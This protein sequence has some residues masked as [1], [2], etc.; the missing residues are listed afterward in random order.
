M[1][2][3]DIVKLLA[4][5][6]QDDVF[7]PECKNGPTH[8]STHTRLDAWA[9]KK[10][11]QNPLAIG[12]EIKV[13]RGDFLRDEKWR[14]YLGLCNQFYFVAP[15]GVIKPEEVPKPAGLIMVSATGSRLFT[16]LKAQYRE[17]QIPDSL[18]RYVLFSRV[19]VVDEYNSVVFTRS[20]KLAYWK[21][22]MEDKKIDQ[23]F[24]WQVSRSIGH[25]VEE[26]INKANREAERAMSLV[27][28]YEEFKKV[29]ISNGIDPDTSR[30]GFD[31]KVKE[32]LSGIPKTM[33]DDL[34]R[35]RNNI[36]T[37]E[38]NLQTVRGIV[39]SPDSHRKG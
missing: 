24:G 2:A 11:W 13:S 18:F 31:S 15:H 37:M 16:K 26:E 38:K 14:S 29:L 10:S 36:V 4:D 3:R 12:Y 9:I 39:D 23:E 33:E 7:V 34:A 27:S 19:K 20:L 22:W 25:R 6:H 5:R 1:N 32:L 28:T 30:W 17:V 8:G 21:K 35:L